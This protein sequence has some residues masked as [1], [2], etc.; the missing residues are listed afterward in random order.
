MPKINAGNQEIVLHGHTVK[1]FCKPS[2]ND[3]RKVIII[4]SGF[5]P[6]GTLDFF[7]NSVKPIR[8]EVIWIHDSFGEKGSMSYYLFNKGK[9]GPENAIADFIDI[10]AEDRGITRQDIILAGFSKGGTAALYY[11]YKLG[12]GACVVTVPQFAIG[13]YV[14][15]YWGG[16]YSEFSGDQEDFIEMADAY[17]S[18]GI[19]ESEVKPHIYLITSDAD[20]QF[21]TEI[22]PNLELLTSNENFNLIKTESTLVSNHVEVTPYN[23]PTIQSLF[24]LLSEGIIPKIGFSENGITEEPRI[25]YEISAD[26]DFDAYLADLKVAD[27]HMSIVYDS[28]V[29][30]VTNDRHGLT[31]RRISIGESFTAM[32]GSIYAAENSKKYYQ[33]QFHDYSHTRTRPVDPQG[34]LL[35]NL[36]E[37]TH[38]IV[39]QTKARNGGGNWLETPL[40]SKR[41]FSDLVFWKAIITGSNVTTRGLT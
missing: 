14:K 5:R 10:V 6:A 7:G 16:I 33:S 12:V 23:V 21:E 2:E 17:I 20:P 31:D 40:V 35:E 11:A 28:I 29:R 34:I 26:N 30:G 3:R 22:Q 1:Y 13:S 15:N 24:L 8:N 39:A 18:N 4:F 27:G 32:M 41:K 36:P 38:L 9:N 19:Q 25:T 37:G